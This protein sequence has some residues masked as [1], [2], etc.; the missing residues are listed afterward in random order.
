MAKRALLCFLVILCFSLTSAATTYTV[1][2]SSGWDISTDLDTWAQGKNFVVGDVLLFQYTSSDSVNEVTKEAFNSCNTTNVIKTYTNG[3]TTV[4][5]SRPGPWF[6]ISGNKLYCLGGMKLEA[7]VQG[8]QAN[9]PVAAPQA[10]PGAALPQPSS[11]NNNPIPTSAGFVYS[12]RDSLLKAFFGFVAAILW[13]V[14]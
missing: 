1:G 2:D 9:S 3:N 14:G 7:N 6:F 8:N 12:G 10:Q 11:K 5:L 4:T 13:F